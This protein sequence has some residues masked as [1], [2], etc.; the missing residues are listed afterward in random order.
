MAW[1]IDLDGVIWLS[2][3]PI[4]GSPEAVARLRA[5]GERVVFITN[6]SGPTVAE[7]EARLEAIGIPAAGDLLTS[8]MAVA[9]LVGAGERVLVV[10]GPGVVEAVTARGATVVDDRGAADAVIVGLTQ[11]FDYERLRVAAMAVRAGARLLAANDDATMPTPDGEVPG[12][13][14]LL[15]AVATAAGVAPVIAGKP[16]QPM[17]DAAL[18]LAGAGPH[19]VVGDRWSTDGLFAVRMGARFGLVLSGVTR[20]EM[21]GGLDP[22]PHAVAGDL[23]SLVTRLLGQPA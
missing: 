20:P 8:A 16:H 21:V 19:I 23:A 18:A 10:G 3:R 6:Y 15:A 14:S 17:V 7:Q 13:G 12:A 22:A 11:D 4:P 2:G 5:R 1:L 9:T